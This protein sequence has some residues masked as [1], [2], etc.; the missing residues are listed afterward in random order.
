MKPGNVLHICS[1]SPDW[2]DKDHVMLH[3]CFQLLCDWWAVRRHGDH[4]N[5]AAENQY[6]Q[7]DAMLARLLRVRWALWV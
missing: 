4:S 1:L 2:C 3:A 6:Q 5:D 7:D